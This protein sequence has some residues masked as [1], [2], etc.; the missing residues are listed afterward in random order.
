[1]H[2][3]IIKTPKYIIC[4]YN[5]WP[6]QGRTGRGREGQAEIEAGMGD[7]GMVIP[8]IE[9]R[10]MWGL[11]LSAGPQQMMKIFTKKQLPA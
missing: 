11:H 4:N 3:L 6:E 2:R 1:M 5:L 9:S 10:N 8:R 7:D